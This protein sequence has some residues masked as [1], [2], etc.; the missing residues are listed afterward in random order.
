MAVMCLLTLQS[1]CVQFEDGFGHTLLWWARKS[2]NTK[3]A[4]AVIQF[5]ET[6]GIKVC[7]GDL[8][9]EA[10][11]MATGGSTAWCD[12]LPQMFHLSGWRL[13]CLPGVL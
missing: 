8:A 6:R 5:I 11:S 3:V 4:E 2:G 7:E 9:V 1:N 10:S 12:R 13:R